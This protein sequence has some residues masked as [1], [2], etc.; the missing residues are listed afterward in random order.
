[1]IE[2]DITELQ[3]KVDALEK[4]LGISFVRGEFVGYDVSPADYHDPETGVSVDYSHPVENI[5][6]LLEYRKKK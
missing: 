5:E 6:E 4:F 3:G 2:D 1:M